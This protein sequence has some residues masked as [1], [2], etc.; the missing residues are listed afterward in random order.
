MR[1]YFFSFD[2]KLEKKRKTVRWNIL[3]VGSISQ[4]NVRSF[5]F[6]FFSSGK[7]QNLNH[8]IQYLGISLGNLTTVS[9]KDCPTYSHFKI[10]WSYCQNSYIFLFFFVFMLHPQLIFNSV[11]LIL[12]SWYG[13]RKDAKF[14]A[15]VPA[16]RLFQRYKTTNANTVEASNGP[17]MKY[18]CTVVL[19]EKKNKKTK[20]NKNKKTNKQKANAQKN[21]KKKKKTQTKRKMLSHYGSSKDEGP[22]A[23][24][25]RSLLKFICHP[26]LSKNNNSIKRGFCGYHMLHSSLLYNSLP[27]CLNFLVIILILN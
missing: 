20:Q 23:K 26:R 7:D 14:N 13:P 18:H 15:H 21:K 2:G 11:D 3:T 4:W 8:R 22:E 10:T 17:T 12:L 27:L 19:A 6:S 24:Q 1:K 9:A 5:H 16:I 25:V